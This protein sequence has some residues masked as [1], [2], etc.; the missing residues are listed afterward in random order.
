MTNAFIEITEN[1]LASLFG[2][3]NLNGGLVVMA[4]L[5]LF[6][7]FILFAARAGKIVVLL[8]ILP[9]ILTIAL[10][11][12]QFFQIAVW[13]PIVAFLILGAIFAG[14]YFVFIK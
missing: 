14:V 8:V 3:S 13:I 6:L 12:T 4:F 10:Y 2:G 9:V 11:P 7:V 1:F 5:L